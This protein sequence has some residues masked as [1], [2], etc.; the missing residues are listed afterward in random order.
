MPLKLTE[1]N[2]GSR[3]QDAVKEREGVSLRESFDLK[4]FENPVWKSVEKKKWRHPRGISYQ[5]QVANHVSTQRQTLLGGTG[6]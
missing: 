6:L 2:E 1:V 5:G 4:L 3:A